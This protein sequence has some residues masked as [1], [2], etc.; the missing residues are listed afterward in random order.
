MMPT[1]PD[2][3]ILSLPIELAAIPPSGHDVQFEAT[4]SQCEALAAAYGLVGVT[5]LSAM[6]NLERRKTGAFVSGRIAGNIVQN[7]IITLEPVMQS[8]EETVEVEFIAAGVDGRSPEV[9]FDPQ[10]PDRPDL[11]EDG[12]ADLGALVEEHFV[13]AIDPYPRREGVEIPVAYRPP[14]ASGADSPFS[15]LLALR[16]GDEDPGET[17]LKSKD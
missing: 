9:E 15:T 1:G 5:S 11:L 17:P 8:I 3:P 13:L 16:T 2:L 14:A 12:I 10:G 7:C 6:I 4:D